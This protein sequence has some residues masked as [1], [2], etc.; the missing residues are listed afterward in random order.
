MWNQ[1]V[2]QLRMRVECQFEILIMSRDSPL[3]AQTLTFVMFIDDTA[4]MP[5]LTNGQVENIPCPNKTQKIILLITY[6]YFLKITTFL[7]IIII[8]HPDPSSLLL[9]TVTKKFGGLRGRGPTYGA[10]D[11]VPG[12]TNTPCLAVHFAIAYY[13]ETNMKM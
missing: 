9:E 4:S 6:V 5:E 3:T 12:K 7:W 13:E 1:Q 8:L 2:F 10:R 11:R